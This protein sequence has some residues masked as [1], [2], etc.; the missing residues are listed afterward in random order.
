MMMYMF[1]WLLLTVSALAFSPPSS[2]RHH[3]SLRMVEP[4]P[5]ARVDTASLK[6]LFAVSEGHATDDAASLDNIDENVAESTSDGI[7]MAAGIFGLTKAILGAGVFG[8]PYG[9]AAMSDYPRMLWPANIM[10]IGMGLLSGYT[11]S[12]YGRLHFATNTNSL[13]DLWSTV[14]A[15]NETDTGSTSTATTENRK[16]SSL[17]ISIANF[18]YCCGCCLTFLLVIGDSLMSIA[19]LVT[20]GKAANIWWLSRQTFIL[21]VAKSTLWP[22]CNLKSL[23]ALAPVSMLGVLG[24]LVASVFVVWRCP[25]VVASSPYAISAASSGAKYQA[26]AAAASSLSVPK[27]SSYNRVKGPAPLV[28]FSMGCVAL[29]AHFSAPAFLESFRS[30]KEKTDNDKTD[31]RALR[32]YNKMTVGGYSL[33]AIVNAAVLTFGF[34]TFGGNSAGIIL[35]NYAASDWGATLSRLLVTVSVTGSFPYLLSASRSSARDLL[36]IRNQSD[37]SRRKLTAV[38]LSSLV[39]ITMVVRN[40]GFVVSFV[41][42]LMGTAI[43]Y[44]FPAMMY[45]KLSSPSTSNYKELG[46][47]VRGLERQFC[48]FLTGFGVLAALIGA[49]TSVMNSYFPHLL[50]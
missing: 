11:F 39:A 20:G 6:P 4:R 42:A 40:A 10:M 9:L 5:C 35:N 7:S 2:R 18:V 30:N 22:L 41:G 33:V 25:A 26:S 12:L 8:L 50:I 37:A 21:S 3:A 45:L 32:R 23:K 34:L 29:M 47:R 48:R 14:F 36:G 31:R 15:K 46:G 43:L 17:P 27:F 28:L 49:A 44:I 38:L 13:G 1:R 19:E 24:S 16:S